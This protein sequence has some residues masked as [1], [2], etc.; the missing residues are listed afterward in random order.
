MPTRMPPETEEGLCVSHLVL[1][2][3]PSVPRNGSDT[4]T[5]RAE[6]TGKLLEEKTRGE[7]FDLLRLVSDRND[8]M[9]VYFAET[10][11]E[12][13]R[14]QRTLLQSPLGSTLTRSYSFLSVTELSTYQSTEQRVREQLEEE[15]LEEGSPE[16]EDA[17][18]RKMERM[19]KYKASRL[20]PEVPDHS[21]ATFYPMLKRREPE[22]NWYQLPSEKRAELMANHGR[23]G[24]KYAGDIQQIITSC[25]GIDDWEWGVTLYADDPRHLKQVVYEMRF[26]EVSAVYSDFGPFFTGYRV[27]PSQLPSL[28]ET[29]T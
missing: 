2:I 3:T 8:F 17:Y 19:E 15:G 4:L 6:E 29:H 24:R 25:V 10:L 7:R 16:Y 21:C 28:F 26:D 5:K 11:P 22:Q 1:R 9:T 23:I 12:I 13:D 14:F 20:R 18:E 27:E